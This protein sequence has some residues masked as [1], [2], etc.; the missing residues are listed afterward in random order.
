[1]K[2]YEVAIG[3]RVH[4]LNRVPIQKLCLISKTVADAGG[5]QAYRRAT[6]LRAR[7][8]SIA[9]GSVWALSDCLSS[10]LCAVRFGSRLQGSR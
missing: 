1:M 10:E 4:L 8:V 6:L 9:S 5:M 2:A 7:R 3:S